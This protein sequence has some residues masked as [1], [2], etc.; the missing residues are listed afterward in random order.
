MPT[1]CQHETALTVALP[2]FPAGEADRRRLARQLDSLARQSRVASILLLHAA[3]APPADFDDDAGVFKPLAI[4]AWLSEKDV[5]RL[6]DASETDLLLFLPPAD[7]MQIEQRGLEQFMAVAQASGAGLVYSDFREV[8]GGEIVEQTMLDYQPGSIRENFD[9]GGLVYISRHAARSVLSRYA[10]GR[11]ALRWAGLY[12][13]WL[14]L[15]TDFPIVRIPE[16][17][18]VRARAGFAAPHRAGFEFFSQG[19]REHQSEAERVATQ[20]LH[21]IGAYL[22]SAYSPLPPAEDDF[23]VTASVIIPVRNREQTI[24]QAV[25]SA[26]QQK[27]SFP[28]NVIVVDDRSS[29]RTTAIIGEVAREHDSIV[30]R[31]PERLDLGVG[32]LWNEA[33]NL[34]ECGRLAVQLDS[35]D[36]YSGHHVLE[37][38]VRKFWELPPNVEIPAPGV[39]PRYAM[40][41]GSY[42]PVNFNLAELSSN[43]VN[44]PE[45]NEENGRNNALRVDGPGAPRAFYVPVL[46]RLGFPNVSF[47]EDY[48]MLL[49]I[50]REY[51]VGRIYDSLC[52]VRRWK[53][54]LVNSLPLG[55]L[56]SIDLQQL[57]PPGGMQEHEFLS[58][59]QP[60][61]KPLM[62][63]SQNHY[64]GYKDWLRTAEIQARQSLNKR[65]SRTPLS[66]PLN[67]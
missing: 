1:P 7:G 25:R 36:V 31:I 20:H 62:S 8:N 45:L 5:A 41:V 56:K 35:D 66:D 12:D 17:L 6:V 38:I 40:V 67:Q 60:I 2:Y 18:Y 63:A 3:G 50:G 37:R 39:P 55:S 10:G 23:P 48:A 9:F 44:H 47:S 24:A 13:L 52:L 29:D 58:L 11:P 30:H 57:L 19:K 51:E 54:N 32:G 43:V 53:G 42:T 4:E 59:M 33:I 26:C 34:P 22:G 14:K 64:R 46:R 16:P 27:T 28:F 61:L 21:R 15:S 65:P 49:R